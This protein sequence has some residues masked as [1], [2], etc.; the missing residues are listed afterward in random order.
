[1][2]VVVGAAS[3]SRLVIL[4]PLLL[5]MLHDDTLCICFFGDIAMF[6]LFFGVCLSKKMEFCRQNGVW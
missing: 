4:S 1:M 2:I 3:S 5:R 6:S